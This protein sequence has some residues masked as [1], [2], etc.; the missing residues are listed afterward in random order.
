MA[1]EPNLTGVIAE[2]LA[3]CVLGAL[4]GRTQRPSDSH[5]DDHLP[6]QRRPEG[7]LG[8]ADGR[9]AVAAGEGKAARKA[10]KKQKVKA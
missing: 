4:R 3:R 8:G 5:L 6:F 1:L 9:A 10:G 2:L 7:Q